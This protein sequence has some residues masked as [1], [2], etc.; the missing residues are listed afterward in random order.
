MRV[1][2][3]FSV[4]IEASGPIPGEYSMLSLGACRVDA[5]DD[6][7]Y[8][9]FKP[10]SEGFVQAALDVS[11]FDLAGLKVTGR[12]SRDG[13]AEF[14]DWIERSTAER[15]PVFVG[16]NAGFDW[17]FVNWYFHKFLGANP[18]GISALDIKAYYMGLS[19]CSWDE[20]RS[21]SLPS[22]LKSDEPGRHAHNALSDAVHQAHI[23]RRMIEFRNQLSAHP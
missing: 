2:A 14:R 19:G 10:V 18:F 20:T 21:S 17:S 9:E 11:G 1:E 15:S 16:F 7:F 6:T 3:Y 12:E 4:D 8:C 5:P 13:M 23:F 22:I